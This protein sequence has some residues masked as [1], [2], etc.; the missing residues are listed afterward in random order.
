VDGRWAED[1]TSYLV[2]NAARPVERDEVA[3][4]RSLTD[5]G[6][7]DS[8]AIMS[9]LDWLEVRFGVQFEPDEVVIGNFDTVAAIEAIVASKGAAG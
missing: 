4:A 9:M 3:S 1:I 5:D 6:I 7:I 2:E 8:L